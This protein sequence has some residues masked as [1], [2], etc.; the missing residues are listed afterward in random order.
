[1]E[2]DFS[3]YDQL[4][5]ALEDYHGEIAYKVAGKI[6]TYVTS[7][8]VKPT[9][10]NAKRAWKAIIDTARQYDGE[11][12]YSENTIQVIRD[13]AEVELSRGHQMGMFHMYYNLWEKDVTGEDAYWYMIN[14]EAIVEAL[15]PAEKL[16]KA[17]AGWSTGF[18]MESDLV[19]KLFAL[20]NSGG[21]NLN[22]TLNDFKLAFSA[23]SMQDKSPLKGIQEKKLN[24]GKRYIHQSIAY[25]FVQLRDNE[26]IDWE[27]SSFDDTFKWTTGS[28]KDATSY[29]SEILEESTYKEK[30][31][32]EKDRLDQ[33]L[34]ELLADS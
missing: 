21:Y 7:V 29:F 16:Q 5:I 8:G 4:V 22:C 1:M 17:K 27:G 33:I 10:V 12:D 25:L 31:K 23:P 34:I 18:K 19:E 30:K 20:C 15:S 11:V 14:P 6:Q 28:G 32:A 24:G 13:Y 26:L 9:L 2:P 3:H